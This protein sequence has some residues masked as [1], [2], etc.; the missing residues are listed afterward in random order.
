MKSVGREGLLIAAAAELYQRRHGV[1]PATIA[2]LV[3]DFLKTAPL[4]P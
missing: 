1:W 3:P 2:S 4:D